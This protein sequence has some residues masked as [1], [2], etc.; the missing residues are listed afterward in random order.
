MR[1]VIDTNVWV[2]RLLLANSTAAQAVDRVLQN[3]EA[4][5]SE[6][7]VEELADVLSRRK[8]DKYV[9]L[10]DRQEFLRRVLQVTTVVPVL[11]VVTDCRDPT[12]NGFLALALDSGSECM[13]SGDSDL[14]T[15]SPWRDIIIV[16][17]REFLA[18]LRPQQGART[19]YGQNDA[20]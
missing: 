13:I 18:R 2:S 3:H 12:D 11:S 17:P 16:P 9:S 1:V 19:P 14:I 7:S 20:T 10:E 6:A 8:F 5:V 4:V 15:L